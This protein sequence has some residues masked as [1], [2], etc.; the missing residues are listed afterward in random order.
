EMINLSPSESIIFDQLI[1]QLQ[2]VGFDI[3]SLGS[4]SYSIMAVPLG[5][6]GIAPES[7]VSSILQDALQGEANAS[8]TVGHVIACALA[9]KVA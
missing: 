6:E 3:S 9:R 1:P 5:T 2:V 4:G 8:E 7:L